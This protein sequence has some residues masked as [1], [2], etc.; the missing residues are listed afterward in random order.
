MPTPNTP[1]SQANQPA[2]LASVRDLSVEF[3]HAIAAIA[4]N[5]L[6][7]L[8][9]GISNQ[10]RLAEVLRQNLPGGT[11]LPDSDVQSAATRMDAAE[12]GELANLTRLYSALLQRSMRSVRL[13]MALCRTYRQMLPNVS[14]EVIAATTLSC[15]V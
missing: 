6:K 1:E 3:Q 8:E 11:R 9:A 4:S 12:L 5:D 14:D 10:E 15:E 7:T 13:R 2:Y